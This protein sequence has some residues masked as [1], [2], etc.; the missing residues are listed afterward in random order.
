[1][2]PPALDMTMD[3]FMIDHATALLNHMIS[4]HRFSVHHPGRAYGRMCPMKRHA[5][6]QQSVLFIMV[7][8]YVSQSI[9]INETHFIELAEWLSTLARKLCEAFL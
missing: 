8:S 3:S 4:T 9:E 6:F 5:R 7:L 2:Q 1:M